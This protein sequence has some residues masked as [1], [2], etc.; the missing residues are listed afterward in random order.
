LTV[1]RAEAVEAVVVTAA[2]AEPGVAVAAGGAVV[3]GGAELRVIAGVAATPVG[4][5]D[6]VS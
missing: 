4:Y 3:H 2:V 5:V 6:V 1:E